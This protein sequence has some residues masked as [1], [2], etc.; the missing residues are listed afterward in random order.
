M[1]IESWAFRDP[2]LY[3]LLI[4]DPEPTIVWN[5]S[6]PMAERRLWIANALYYHSVGCTDVICYIAAGRALRP[7]HPS[8]VFSL[9]D[10]DSLETAQARCGPDLP[11]IARALQ[12]PESV[13]KTYVT[14]TRRTCC[15]YA[16]SAD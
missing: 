1:V 4:A 2:R 9:I 5:T 8:V 6:L 15:K 3:G 14:F 12:V 10:D 16:I 7:A 11:A 13:V